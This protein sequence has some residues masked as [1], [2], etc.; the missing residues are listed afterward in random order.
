MYSKLR[1]GL[2]KNIT[3]LIL[4]NYVNINNNNKNKQTEDNL[5]I[6]TRFLAK[7]PSL[8]LH[9][10]KHGDWNQEG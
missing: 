8:L 7:S 3:F 10:V 9:R 2:K 6:K 5:Y 1:I 4:N